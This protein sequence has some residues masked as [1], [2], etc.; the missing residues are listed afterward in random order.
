MADILF[1]QDKGAKIE[2]DFYKV[3]YQVWIDTH[4]AKKMDL[5]QDSSAF[6]TDGVKRKYVHDSVHYSLALTPGKPIYEDFLKEGASVDMDMKKVWAADK[7]VVINMFREEVAATAL[8]RIVIP[9]NY[10]CSPGMA[11]TWALRR[12]I[13]SLMRGKSARFMVEN[14]R[15]FML[16][17]DYVQ[18]HLNNSHMLIKL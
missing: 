4:G 1:L 8:E 10:K 2:E 15:E 6:F 3:L 5:N 12:C 7:S 11:W 17:D 13:T 14:F 16:P 9:R 18:R